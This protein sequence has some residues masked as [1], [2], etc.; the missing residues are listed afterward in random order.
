MRRTLGAAACGVALGALLA[1]VAARAGTATVAVVGSAV[2]VRPSETVTG[3]PDATIFGGRNELA[4]F[5]VVVSAGAQA[6][7]GLTVGAGAVAVMSG[8]T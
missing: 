6:M 5:Q 2:K 4:D 8:R 1:P 7:T 3:A